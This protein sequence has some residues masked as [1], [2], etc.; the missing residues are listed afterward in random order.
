MI[1]GNIIDVYNYITHSIKTKY[2]ELQ[3]YFNQ[4]MFLGN[5]E[6]NS[7]TLYNPTMMLLM[8]I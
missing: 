1:K 6:V 4:E 5:K 7:G 8:G 2:C 3:T